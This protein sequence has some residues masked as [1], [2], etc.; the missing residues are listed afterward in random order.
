M[1]SFNNFMTKEAN[2][3]LARHQEYI[4]HKTISYVNDKCKKMKPDYK[5]SASLLEEAIEEKHFRN[6]RNSWQGRKNYADHMELEY[7]GSL[8]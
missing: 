2:K 1:L 6:D 4:D 3:V 8:E 5:I 7:N